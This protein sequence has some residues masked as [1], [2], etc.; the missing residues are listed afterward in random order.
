MSSNGVNWTKV[1]SKCSGGVRKTILETRA[2]H[3][4]LRRQI[5]EAQQTTPKLDFA[6]YRARLPKS[7]AAMVADAEGQLKAFRPPTVDVSPALEQLDKEQQVKV[8][9]CKQT[10]A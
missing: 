6:V 7:M 5:V 10:R 8:G 2:L 4:E 3:E 9:K 1:L